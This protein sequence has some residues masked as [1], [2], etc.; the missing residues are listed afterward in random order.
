MATTTVS[1]PTRPYREH[2]S[3]VLLV[4]FALSAAHTVYVTVADIADPNFT[5]TTPTAWLFYA[6]GFGL[7]AGSRSDRRGVQLAVMAV[8][9]LLLAVALFYYP[10]VFSPRLQNT[11]GWLENDIY[12]GLLMIAEY[13]AVLR[14]RGVTL[15]R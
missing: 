3:R 5:A 7:V 14:F 2:I 11:V 8:L 10:T 15:V 4:A 1:V 6:I 9:G 13:F 12:T